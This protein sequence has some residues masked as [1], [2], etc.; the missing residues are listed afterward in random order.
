MRTKKT[1]IQKFAEKVESLGLK[2]NKKQGYI[3]FCFSETE[4]DKI[5][6]FYSSNGNIANTVECLYSCMKNDTMLANILLAA[7]SAIA[8]ARA[9]QMMELNKDEEPVTTKEVTPKTE[10]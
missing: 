10:N 9:Q 5:Q 2:L 4:D 7:T 3:M 6:S 1:S 8:Q